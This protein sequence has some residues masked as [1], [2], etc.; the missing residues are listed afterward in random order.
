[1][2]GLGAYTRRHMKQ[3]LLRDIKQVLLIL[4]LV[5]MAG[6][7]VTAQAPGQSGADTKI[8]TATQINGT[9]RSGKNEFKILAL[10]GGKL[11]VEFSGVYEYRSPQGPSANVGEG[12]GIA[13]I[14]G[15]TI[16]F[17]PEVSEDECMITMKYSTGRLHVSQSGICGFGFNVTAEGTYRRVSASKPK[18]SEH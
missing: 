10:G 3:L 2:V 11:R 12:W 1:M 6:S 9:W 16:R 13:H 18:F 14:E 15:D 17:K 8:V 7:V 5:L 4:S